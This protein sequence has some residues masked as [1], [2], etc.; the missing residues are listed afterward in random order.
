MLV[1]TVTLHMFKIKATP[2]SIRVISISIQ[3]HSLNQSNDVVVV[4]VAS[5]R[6]RR[7]FRAVECACAAEKKDCLARRKEGTN[8]DDDATDQ[9]VAR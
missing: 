2:S 1:N 8:D 3:L 9:C 4:V 6:A 5:E 7:S